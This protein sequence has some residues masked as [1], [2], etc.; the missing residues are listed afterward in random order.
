M[1]TLQRINQALNE[2]ALFGTF[3][4]VPVVDEDF[5]RQPVYKS[6]REGKTNGVSHS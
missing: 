5:I 3:A 6:L 1:S 4:L 2:E